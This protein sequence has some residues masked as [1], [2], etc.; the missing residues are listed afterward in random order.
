MHTDDDHKP[1]LCHTCNLEETASLREAEE[2]LLRFF[3]FAEPMPA[4]V[5]S[6]SLVAH[7]VVCVIKRSA[8]RTVCLRELLAAKEAALRALLPE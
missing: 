5:K 7:E 6:I 3:R 8:E 1:Q 4:I 2:P